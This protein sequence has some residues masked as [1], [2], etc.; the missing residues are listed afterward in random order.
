MNRRVGRHAR[1]GSVTADAAFHQQLLP[2]TASCLRTLIKST[3]L[4]AV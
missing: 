4:H 1:S 2:A 3:H